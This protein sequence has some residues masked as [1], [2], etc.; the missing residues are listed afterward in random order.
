[1]TALRE[2]EHLAPSRSLDPRLLTGGQ[3]TGNGAGVGRETVKLAEAASPATLGASAWHH[4][5]LISK[6]KFNLK[7]YF[8]HMG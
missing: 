8:S 1:M 3:G 6:K 4:A 2:H 7:E 5:F